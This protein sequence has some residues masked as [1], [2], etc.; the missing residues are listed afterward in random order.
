MPECITHPPMSMSRSQ[1]HDQLKSDCNAQ[2]GWIKDHVFVDLCQEQFDALVN[3]SGHK[4]HTDE[5]LV[6]EIHE[7]WCTDN[8]AVRKKYLETE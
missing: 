1:A 8:E 6:K 3:I 5:D 7:K 2:A 4:G